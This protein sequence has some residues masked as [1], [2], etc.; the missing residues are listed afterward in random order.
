MCLFWLRNILFSIFLLFSFIYPFSFIYKKVILYWHGLDSYN[1]VL[2]LLIIIITIS[3]LLI[4]INHKHDFMI[5]CLQVFLFCPSMILVFCFAFH[6]SVPKNYL[7]TDSRSENKLLIQER[8]YVLDN[9]YYICIYDDQIFH[10]CYFSVYSKYNIFEDN[11]ITI[12][13]ESDYV[14]IIID[15]EIYEVEF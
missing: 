1:C 13:W 8:A 3:L 6:F 2:I 9:E 4:I 15:N 14:Q 11:K 5:I 12:N 7:L 10:K